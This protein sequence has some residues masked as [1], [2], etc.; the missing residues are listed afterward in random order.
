MTIPVL[1][2][3]GS[4][5]TVVPVQQSRALAQNLTDAGADVAF[6]QLSSGDHWLYEYGTRL[7]VLQELEAFLNTHLDDE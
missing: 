3:H 6:I 5:D 2:L 4:D 7:R 1:L